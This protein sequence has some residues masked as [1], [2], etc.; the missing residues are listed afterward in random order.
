MRNDVTAVLVLHLTKGTPLSLDERQSTALK[1][2]FDDAY[3]KIK[4]IIDAYSPDSPLSNTAADR[5]FVLKLPE[6]SAVLSDLLHNAI[7]CR[8][9]YTLRFFALEIG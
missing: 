3:N 6:Q 4:G 1:T 7:I 8:Y 2:M 9:P 5:V